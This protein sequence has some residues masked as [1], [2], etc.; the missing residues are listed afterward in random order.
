MQ[1]FSRWSQVQVTSSMAG[2]SSPFLTLFRGITLITSTTVTQSF[3]G[4]QV[5]WLQHPHDRDYILL[6]VIPSLLLSLLIAMA[7]VDAEP[8]LEWFDYIVG[9]GLFYFTEQYACVHR[10]MSFQF[11][12]LGELK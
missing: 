11:W 6:I 4:K 2:Y 10:S 3:P 7:S 12:M 8:F 1:I 5:L 9:A